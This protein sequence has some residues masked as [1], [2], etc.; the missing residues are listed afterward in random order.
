MMDEVGLK[1]TNLDRDPGPV[2]DDPRALVDLS[3]AVLILHR[4]QDELRDYLRL[5]GQH[6]S[7]HILLALI[8]LDT[9]AAKLANA[10]QEL[11][12]AQP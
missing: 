7:R 12:A 9:V 2:P 4:A 6:A 8:D 3:A 11:Q 10:L 1:Q 5:D